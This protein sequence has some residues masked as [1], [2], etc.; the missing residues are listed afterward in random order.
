MA[1]M[2]VTG[3]AP[4]RSN[5][6]LWGCLA[7]LAFIFLPVMLAGGYGAWFLYQGFRH[8]PV[9]RTVTELTRRDGLAH[10]VLGNDIAV[11]GVAGNVFTFMPGIG[12]HTSYQVTVEGDKAGGILDV[13]AETSG[14][15]V[16]IRSMIL[17]TPNGGRYD[18]LHNVV[19]TEPSGSQSI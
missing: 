7:I 12:S 8:D 3:Q 2:T 1:A 14:G 6:C 16:E 15:Q 10:Q 19:L 4:R 13:E 5:G 18:L 11:T 9:L 17:T